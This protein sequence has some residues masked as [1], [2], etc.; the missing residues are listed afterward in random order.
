[1]RD[2]GDDIILLAQAFVRRFA[3]QNGRS[4]PPLT[5]DCRAKLMRY[6]WPGNVRELEN[7]IERAF[8][9]SKDGRKLNLDRALPD[10]TPRDRTT[11]TAS[12][13]PARI[14]TVTELRDMERD[15]LTRALEASNWKIS[16]SGGAAERLGL[17]PNTL[18][19]RMKTLGVKRRND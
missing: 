11:A 16:G 17:N 18:S 14:L 6:D 2:R 1:L 9:T 3:K 5:E 12:V 15:N 8:I 13:D 10:V 19:S 4:A 7:V